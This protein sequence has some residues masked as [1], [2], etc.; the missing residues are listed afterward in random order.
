MDPNNS[1]ECIKCIS[2]LVLGKSHFTCEEKLEHC[3]S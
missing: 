3:E 1:K 2:E